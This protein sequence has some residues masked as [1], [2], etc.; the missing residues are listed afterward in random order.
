MVGLLSFKIINNMLHFLKRSNKM[1]TISL[2]NFM[3]NTKS[4]TTNVVLNNDIF[5]ITTK[6]GNVVLLSEREFNAL[7]NSMHKSTNLFNKI[8]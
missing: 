6:I 7:L 1:N 3:N 5:K 8:E 4:I 2:S